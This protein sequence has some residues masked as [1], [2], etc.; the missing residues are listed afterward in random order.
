MTQKGEPHSK[1][2]DVSI[3][4]N[5]LYSFESRLEASQFTTKHS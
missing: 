4:Q 5:K 1:D 3:S 2:I